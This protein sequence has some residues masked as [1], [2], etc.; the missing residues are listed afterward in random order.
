MIE[1]VLTLIGGLKG[2][3]IGGLGLLGGLFGL[4]YK[5]RFNREREEK[6]K[7]Q[8]ANKMYQAKD[9]VNRQDQSQDAEVEQKIDLVRDQ[10]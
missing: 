7:A 2:L 4:F 9:A 1:T 6:Q 5:A 3:I 10:S 8:A